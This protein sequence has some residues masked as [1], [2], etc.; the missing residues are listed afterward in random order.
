MQKRTR[1]FLPF[2]LTLS[3]IFIIFLLSKLPVFSRLQGGIETLFRPIQSG[4]TQAVL[5]QSE[6]N[7]EK[8]QQENKNLLAQL[9][10][11][12]EIQKDNQA[13]R[14]QFESAGSNSQHLLP[15][16]II[17]M[18]PFIPGVL[19]PEFILIDQGSNSHVVVGQVVL[20]RN[21]F[22][23]IIIS[24]SPKSSKVQ[25]ATNKAVS[26]TAKTSKT[27]AKG[28][29]KG[30]GNGDMVFGNVVLTDKLETGDTIVTAGNTDM[31][32]TTIPEGYAIGK[33]TSVDKKASSLFQS[34][35]LVPLFD[36]TKISDVFV[37][38][39]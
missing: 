38:M 5:S 14:D 13:L 24:V 26:F 27:N 1:L 29:F 9:S 6:S 15:A 4:M 36:I 10:R 30:M 33:I 31:R 22:V 16:K 37:L 12:Q 2:L 39:R 17:G 25:L 19:T 23:G 21:I 34:A 8:L 7:I 18:Q 32:N 11:M 20:V 35:G 3:I 28:I